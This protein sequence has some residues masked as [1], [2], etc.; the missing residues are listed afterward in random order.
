MYLQAIKQYKEKNGLGTFRPKTVLF[1]MDGVLYDSMPNHATAWV[2]AMRDFQIEMTEEDAYLTEGQKGSDTIM[3]M[4][5]AQQH[6]AIS[7]EE[8]A[9]MYDRKAEI[10]ATLPTAPVMPG[11]L[12]LMR[13]IQQ[14]GWTI[15]IVTGSAQRPLIQRLADDFGE[16]VSSDRIV[17][18]YDVARGKPQPD[19][20]LMG[21]KKCGDVQPWET[22]VVENAPL[23]VQAGVAAGAFTI[24]VST[25]I[26][27]K[28]T[29]AAAGAQVVLD[30]MTR[31]AGD[32]PAFLELL[33]K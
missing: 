12:T 2:Q 15:G 4:V 21:M 22:I 17:T 3:Q 25:G 23:G 14:A 29:L 26:L 18:A 1:D 30:S 31:L 6:R 28:H 11:I 5:L 19:P 9:R 16:F 7:Q 33:D 32:F 10:F 13:E 20:Y 27:P 24:G 8:A